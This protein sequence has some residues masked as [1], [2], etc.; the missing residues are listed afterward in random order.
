[1]S[2]LARYPVTTV[3]KPAAQTTYNHEY[4]TRKYDEATAEYVAVK[5]C[6]NA[7]IV[8]AAYQKLADARELLRAS[9]S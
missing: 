8:A 4:I 1:M 2:L 5:F 6:G 9:V 7:A 3:S